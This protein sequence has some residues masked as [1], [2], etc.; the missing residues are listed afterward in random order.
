[1]GNKTNASAYFKST[2]IAPLAKWRSIFVLVSLAM[3]TGLQVVLSRFLSIE[4]PFFKIG[5]GF[6]PVMIAGGMFGPVGGLIVG[7]VSDLV[8]AILFPFGAYFPG[9]T[10]TAAFSG[11]VYG[12]LLYRRP[13]VFRIVI[14]YLITAL[15][16]TLGFNTLFSILLYVKSDKPFYAK[17]FAYI[18][19][20]L[21]QAGIMFAVQ[22]ALTY[23]LLN[24]LNLVSRIEQAIKH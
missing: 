19:P 15:T 4:T 1:M 5:F 7:G 23:L 8:G 17:Y 20:R 18:S 3:L 9:Y 24:R 22:T 12:C 6:V 21:L 14:A 11:L 13:S 10:L 2:F 16:V